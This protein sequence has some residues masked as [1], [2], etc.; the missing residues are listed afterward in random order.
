MGHNRARLSRENGALNEAYG[1]SLALQMCHFL[2]YRHGLSPPVVHFDF[3]TGNLILYNHG[4]LKFGATL[5][6]LV[7]GGDPEPELSILC[8]SAVSKALD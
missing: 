3:P 8:L 1:R 4:Q 2:E 6:L 5:H 7:N